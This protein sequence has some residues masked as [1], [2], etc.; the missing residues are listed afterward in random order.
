MPY[1]KRLYQKIFL[2][3]LISSLSTVSHA[4][5]S[6]EAL[7]KWFESDD[8]HPPK[9]SVQ[10]NDVDTSHVNS[11]ELTF[12]STLPDKPVHHHENTVTLT[13]DSLQSGWI[14]LQQCHYNLDAVGKLQIAFKQGHV[15]NI[16]ITET[17]NIGKAW[18][19]K[20]S[21]QLEDVGRDAKI[22]LKSDTLSVRAHEDGTFSLNN[23]PYMRRF[24]D[25]YYPMQVT[26]TLQYPKDSVELLAIKPAEQ[27]GFRVT[28]ADDSVTLNAVFEGELR[29][30]VHLRS[31]KQLV[32][33]HKYRPIHPPR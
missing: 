14:H 12:L 24:F 27:P 32:Q 7:E 17:E 19:E 8:W 2:L 13:T 6:Q 33:Q 18:A 28:K 3:L 30:A 20:D 21:V 31:R 16:E 25:G 9:T 26:M 10:T 4:E 5:L 11:G 1:S 15:R 29:T 23:G 22:C